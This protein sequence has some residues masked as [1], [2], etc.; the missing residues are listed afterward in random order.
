MECSEDGQTQ[1]VTDCDAAT[2]YCIG[3]GNCV[4]CTQASHCPAVGECATRTCDNNQCVPIPVTINTPCS[5]G[6][7]DGA[8]NCVECTNPGQC[9]DTDCTNATCVDNTCDS[10]NEPS[11]TDCSAGVCNSSGTCV[12]CVSAG[13]C[14]ASGDCYDPTCSGG[15]CGQTPKNS[16]ELCSGGYC[17]GNGACVECTSPGH[18]TASGDCY[19]PTC[20]G[21][22]C[23]QTPKNSGAT[24]SGGYCNGNGSCVECTTDS[25]C[26]GSTPVCLNGSC[27]ACSPGTTMCA[28]SCTRQTRS[29]S[30]TGNWQNGTLCTGDAYCSSGACVTDTLT[31]GWDQASGPSLAMTSINAQRFEV[32]C[33]SSIQYMGA[34]FAA[35]ASGLAVMAI[36]YHDAANNAPGNVF[37]R[38]TAGSIPSDG[39]FAR[40]PTAAG[41]LLEAGTYW[42][43]I[44]ATSNTTPIHYTDS[45]SG[46]SMPGNFDLSMPTTFAA[47]GTYTDTYHMYVVV[48][49]AP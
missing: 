32:S 49:P 31:L 42:I 13:D 7:C 5:G 17:N 43:A 48:R 2:P 34:Q 11:G 29:C 28:S 44:Q 18:C 25:H 38:T 6:V 14:T 39:A 8:G 9:A 30:S 41:A 40:E 45:G 24:C 47:N 15:S 36:Y 21:G 33:D 16:G 46:R 23:G 35:P 3:A 1:S 4:Q 19:N 10:T 20:S 12:G 22:G 37:V 26:D 27:V